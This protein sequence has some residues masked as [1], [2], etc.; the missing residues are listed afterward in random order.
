MKDRERLSIP[1]D[2][3]L[4]NSYLT[5]AM[6]VIVSRALPDV[7][8][9]LKPSQRRILVAM[10]DLNLGPRSKYRKCAKI[11]G[12]T[13]GNYH[14]HGEAVVYPTLVRLAQ[15]FNMR[16]PLVDGQGNFGSLDGD[17][18]AAMRY[19]EA[20][21]TAVALEML[22]DLEKDTVHFIPNYDETRN[23]PTVLPSRFPNLLVNGSIGIAVGM[24]TSLP[25]NNLGEVCDGIIK[26]IENPDI[27]PYELCQTIQGPDFPTGAIVC[28]RNAFARAYCQGRGTVTIRARSKMEESKGKVNIVFTEIPFQ[29]NKASILESI[30]ELVK[31]DKIVGITD[32]RDESDREHLVR[33]VVEVKKGESP[34]IILNQL[35]KFTA[36]QSSFSIIM[37]ALV[38]GRPQVLN[39]KELVEYF[40]RHRQE[41]IRRRTQYLLQRNQARAHIVDGLMLAIQHIDSII[42]IIRQAND[43]QQ[44]RENLMQQFPLS[45]AQTDAILQARLGAITHLESSKLQQER[46]ELTTKINEY[47]NILN[48]PQQILEVIKKETLEIK[49]RYATPRLTEIGDAV[50]EIDIEDIIPNQRCLVLVTRKGYIKRM[51][52]SLYRNQNRGGKGVIGAEVQDGDFVERIFFAFT[53]DYLLLVSSNGTAYWLKCYEIPESGRNTKGRAIVNL[54]HLSTDET[55]TSYIPVNQFDERTLVMA[56]A[57]GV[58]KKTP[59]QSFARPKRTGIHAINLD[60]GDHLIDTLLTS[61]QHDIILVTNYGKAI[62]FTT[63]QLR[64][65]GRNTRGV[66]GCKMQAGDHVIGM[67]TANPEEK[68]LTVSEKG[69]G[70]RSE[71]SLFRTARR[72]GSGVLCHRVNDKTG[73]VVSALSVHE[74]DEIMVIT[75]KG[76]VIRTDANKLRDTARVTQGIRVIRLEEGDYVVSIAH[77]VKE[78]GDAELAA[79]EQTPIPPSPSSQA[80][81]EAV[82]VQEPP[83]KDRLYPPETDSLDDNDQGEDE[84][85]EDD[86]GFKDDELEENGNV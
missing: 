76:I 52:I 61:T 60:E 67:V 15:P 50:E 70:K 68:L 23:E 69:L 63:D 3:E 24:S 16:N 84:H 39:I 86:N 77:M 49:E 14:P 18:P 73:K 17:P 59:L 29:I 9:G 53:H 43:I 19:T 36:L 80:N 2:Q 33:I 5:Y 78:I 82:S 41:I 13:S 31:E 12:D 27:T 28:G 8:D 6:S 47:Q 46:N 22:D 79:A 54:L 74:N 83:E 66:R 85:S 44:A 20:R 37:I 21:M 62:R 34:E 64:T 42:N 7:R 45:M 1:I 55:I 57:N 32:V 75:S 71:Y 30:A 72:G 56:T 26:V 40:I 25:P 35:Y 4:K 38:D 51:S 48:D 11:A 81:L 10:N 65:V 58:I